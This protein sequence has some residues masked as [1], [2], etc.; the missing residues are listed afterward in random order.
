[1]WWR[2][3]EHKV[4]RHNKSSYKDGW[5][6]GVFERAITKQWISIQSFIHNH[7][8]THTQT[9]THRHTHLSYFIISIHRGT[10]IDSWVAQLQ[11]NV[12]HVAG[13]RVLCSVHVCC[14]CTTDSKHQGNFTHKGDCHWMIDDN[15]LYGVFRGALE[16]LQG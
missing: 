4:V 1:M 8:H 14:C 9:D 12:P 13:Q 5:C 11:H 15:S 2:V 10:K 6:S 7:T 3:C 16:I